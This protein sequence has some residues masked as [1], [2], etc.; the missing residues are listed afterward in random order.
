MSSDQ[1]LAHLSVSCGFEYE[2]VL[3]TAYGASQDSWCL[4]PCLWTFFFTTR[5]VLHPA[6]QHC[7]QVRR[8]GCYQWK[9]FGKPDGTMEGRTAIQEHTWIMD[10]QGTRF[11]QRTGPAPCMPAAMM[12]RSSCLV[13]TSVCVYLPCAHDD[14]LGRSYVSAGRCDPLRLPAG[15]VPPTLSIHGQRKCSC[16]AA[17]GQE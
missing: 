14:W 11:W 16:F 12:E 17:G 13:E 4:C 3:W 8:Q 7:L 2:S 1:S 6:L 5:L 15:R 10:N 9:D